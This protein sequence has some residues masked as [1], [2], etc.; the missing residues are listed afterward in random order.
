MSDISCVRVKSG[1]SPSMNGFGV[2]IV[3]IGGRQGG[4]AVGSSVTSWKVGADVLNWQ[5]GVDLTYSSM[6]LQKS[7]KHGH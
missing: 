1:F 5:T 6:R 4:T 3:I 7:A 2:V